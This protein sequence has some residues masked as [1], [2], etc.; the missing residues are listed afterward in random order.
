MLQT[1]T[2]ML[3]ARKN[4]EQELLSRI[5]YEHDQQA[6]ALI[7]DQYYTWLC[8]RAYTF[9]KCEQRTQEIVLDVFTKLWNRKDEINTNTQLKSYLFIAVRNRALDYFRQERLK[10]KKDTTIQAFSNLAGTSPEDDFICEEFAQAIEIAIHNL[11]PQGQLIFRLSREK[12]LKYREIAEELCI[13][14]KTV[15]THMRRAFI[16][17]REELGPWLRPK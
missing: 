17:L 13:S 11:P 2:T 4:S 10:Q 16:Q 5:R 3:H 15:E 6:F 9:C 12:N 7:F 1:T 14:I 8:E